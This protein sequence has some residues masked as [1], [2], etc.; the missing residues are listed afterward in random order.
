[1]VQGNSTLD[2]RAFYSLLAAIV[3]VYVAGIGANSIWTTHESY[4]AVAVREMLESGDWLTITFNGELRFNKPPLTYWL[5]ATSASL[6]GLK[7]WA[8][9]LPILLCSL[10]SLLVTYKLGV[11]LFSKEVGRWALLLMAVSLQFAWLKH[12]AS[13]EIPLTFFFTLTMYGFIRG[14][15]GRRIG[16][17]ILAFTALS[18]TLLV[19]GWPYLLVVYAVLGAFLLLHYRFCL[20]Q[21]KNA[22]PFR[23]FLWGSLAA[24]LIGLSWLGVMYLRYEAEL[25]EVLHF[26]T[27]QRIVRSNQNGFWKQWFFYPE[28][29]VWSFFP[30]SLILYY[31]LF[32]YWKEGLTS[33]QKV[34]LPVA[35]LGVML[36]GFTLAQGKLPAYIL[37]AHPAMALLC[38]YFI[39]QTQQNKKVQRI[40]AWLWGLATF[41]AIIFSIGLVVAFHLSLVWYLVIGLLAGVVIRQYAKHYLQYAPTLAVASTVVALA[42]L[43]LSL[44]PSLEQYRPYRAIQQVIANHQISEEV[45]MVVEERFIHNMPFYAERKVLRNRQYT[46][47]DIVRMKEEEPV[48]GLVKTGHA[49]PTGYEVLWQ[50]SIY[51]KGSES[52]GFRFILHCWYAYQGNNHHFQEYQLV[53]QP[54]SSMRKNLPVALDETLRPLDD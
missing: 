25:L 31:A 34:A 48:L 30:G 35:W 29:I 23:W 44:Y 41:I 13:P 28:A 37:Q 4:Y 42:I 53:Y 47:E 17:L 11:V 8:L 51:R 54:P 24:L 15:S 50:G 40:N 20:S 32:S 52:H 27:S 45:P 2:D 16:Y 46:W 3:G 18:L 21:I 6:F 36:L 19:K 43:F 5:M 39:V 9:R 10:G 12:Y 33:L 22:V 49:L 1:M 26:E 38:A 7:E 14:L